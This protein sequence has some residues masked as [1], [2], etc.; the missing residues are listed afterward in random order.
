MRDILICTV[1]TSLKNNIIYGKN[2]EL[3]HA[4]DA[5]NAKGLIVKLIEL[6]PSEPICGAKWLSDLLKRIRRKL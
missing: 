1:G 5:Q 4:L 2:P 6:S 3:R